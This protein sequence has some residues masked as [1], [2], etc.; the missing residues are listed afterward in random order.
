M[1][2]REGVFVV[3]LLEANDDV[4]GGGVR[5]GSFVDECGAGGGEVGVGEDADGASF[6]VDGEAV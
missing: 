6:D 2:Q 4:G 1:F 5:P 3:E